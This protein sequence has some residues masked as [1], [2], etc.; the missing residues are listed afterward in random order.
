MWRAYAQQRPQQGYNTYMHCYDWR[1][2]AELSPGNTFTPRLVSQTA[3]CPRVMPHDRDQGAAF[4]EAPPTLGIPAARSSSF[5]RPK[6]KAITTATSLAVECR[7]A[8]WSTFRGCRL[9]IQDLIPMTRQMLQRQVHRSTRGGFDACK[10]TCSSEYSRGSMTSS[11]VS[12]PM[13]SLGECL[14]ALFLSHP[15]CH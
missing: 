6:S 8:A 10:S 14:S 4:A 5:G 12:I 2:N 15:R 1:R 3:Q 9:G 13:K 11:L 7:V